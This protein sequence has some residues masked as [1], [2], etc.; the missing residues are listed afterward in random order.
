MCEARVR[1]PWLGAVVCALLAPSPALAQAGGPDGPRNGPVVQPIDPE[2]VPRPALRA[3]A[4]DGEI[5]L[6]G[7]PDE[8]AWAAADS[9]SDFITA[10]PRPGYPASERT[11]VRVLY[12]ETTLYIGAYMF[13][14]EPE[15]LHSPG[16]EQDFPTHA[17]DMFGVSID[18]YLSRQNG[19]MFG[20]SP[21][22]ALFDA[23]SEGD[24]RYINRSW[25]GVVRVATAVHG[26]GWSAELA[27]PFTT[28]RFEAGTTD[29][30]WGMNFLR[31]IRRIN[32]DSYWAPL[33]PQFR[34]H[35]MSR[36]GTVTGLRDLRP[37]RNLTVKPYVRAATTRGPDP[38]ALGLAGEDLDAG[39]D[40]KYG[41]TS[42]LT[43]DLTALTDF[44]QVEVD[45]EQVNL[46]RFSLFFPEKRDFFLENDGIFTLGDVTERNYRTGSSPR[47]FKL[48][49][50]RAVGLTADRRPIP[51]AG[52]ARFSG[53]IG[54]TEVGFMDMQTR[55]LGR[56]GA[57]GYAPAENFAVLRV[58]QPVHGSSDVGF[59]LVN[60]QTT[61]DG[62]LSAWNRSVAV[63][64]NLRLFR[65]LLVNSYAAAT[66][67]PDVDGDRRAG[68]LQV[69]WRDRLLNASAFVKHVGASFNPGVG[70][71]RRRGVRQAFATVG[72]HPRPAWPRV[73]EINPYVDVS[74]IET[75]DGDLETRWFTAGLQTTF[76]DGGTLTFEAED[77]VER[78]FEETEIVGA[79]VAAG[80]YPFRT[81]SI[82]Y[83]SS[84]A[85]WLGGSAR[86]SRGDFYDGR[87]TS[88][89]GNVLFRPNPHV[90]LDL[91][92]QHNR[93]E[94]GGRDFTA[95][96]L[97]AR[98]DVAPSTRLFLSGFVQYVESQDALVT[99]VRLNLIHAPLSDLFLVFTERRDL[100]AG[101]SVDRRLTLKVTRLLAF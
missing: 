24:S 88:L 48:F 74:A 95:D 37:G 63:D 13:D 4:R 96:V 18:S 2:T 8:A 14:S 66:D 90:A 40:L 61:S 71:I 22:G 101:R 68:Y 42:R 15:S 25:E 86:V 57:D 50:S 54:N 46:T 44:S 31:R 62:T 77:R 53:R 85:R 84:G 81:A 92:G 65:Y 59:M 89:Q 11:V 16:L 73:Q 29:A 12:D 28:L 3:R 7:T 26:D 94:L 1:V 52:G 30:G 58:R 99:N 43:L 9:V 69:A 87:R 60:R 55:S 34:L 35:K 39:V 41:I 76:A 91:F 79:S 75:V 70:F 80:R 6:D 36:A 51:I 17:A 33:A 19:V 20:V 83:T 21:A 64:A 97:G 56:P 38:D 100:D 23:Q 49:Y 27:I 32:E 82:A 98:I 78:L 93:L 67:E 5:R 45:Q 72:A 10:L 47:D